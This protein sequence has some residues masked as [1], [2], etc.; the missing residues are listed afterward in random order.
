VSLSGLE[1]RLVS[2]SGVSD[3]DETEVRSLNLDAAASMKTNCDCDSGSLRARVPNVACLPP[4]FGQPLP[5]AHDIFGA[6]NNGAGGNQMLAAIEIN[7]ALWGMIGC[8]VK[9]A[10][11]FFAFVL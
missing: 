7:V 3:R 8:A 9:E 4:G 11:Q 10:A 2:R 5:S 1:I 6:K